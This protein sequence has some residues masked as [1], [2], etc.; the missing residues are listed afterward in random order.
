MDKNTTTS[1]I[2][3]LIILAAIASLFFQVNEIAAEILRAASWIVIG[4][5]FGGTKIAA[6]LTGK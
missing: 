5:Y 3:V 1:I 2:A 6:K 4:F